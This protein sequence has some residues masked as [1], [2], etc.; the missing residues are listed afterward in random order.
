MRRGDFADGAD[1]SRGRRM[2]RRRDVALRFGDQ[3]TLAHRL[4]DQHHRPCRATDML[5]Q[6]YIEEFG[7]RQ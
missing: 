2:H 6:R 7:Q 4:P 1:P 3:L 5:L